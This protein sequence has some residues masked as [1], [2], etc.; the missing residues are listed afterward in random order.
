MLVEDCYTSFFMIHKVEPGLKETFFFG[1]FEETIIVFDKIA[2]VLKII[3]NQTFSISAHFWSSLAFICWIEFFSVTL[4]CRKIK[5]WYNWEKILWVKNRIILVQL[6][7][8]IYSKIKGSQF[9]FK[10]CSFTFSSPR[11]LLEL[12]ICCF[13]AIFVH[14]SCLFATNGHGLLFWIC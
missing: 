3:M 6:W 9:P 12:S 7:P 4:S 14:Y 2:I 8:K 1:M 13:P 5:P 11:H 10:Q